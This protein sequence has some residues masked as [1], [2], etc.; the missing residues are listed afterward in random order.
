MSSLEVNFDSFW[1][2]YALIRDR[3]KE[4][5][6]TKTIPFAVVKEW[7][8]LVMGEIIMEND[9]DKAAIEGEEN[10]G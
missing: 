2:V 10:T 1:T 6:N 4:E 5:I 3:I 9:S 7:A 8:K